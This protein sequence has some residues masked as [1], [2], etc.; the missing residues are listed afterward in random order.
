MNLCLHLM[1]WRFIED[2][3]GVTVGKVCRWCKDVE[4]Y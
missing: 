1:G 3:D 4:W 2:D